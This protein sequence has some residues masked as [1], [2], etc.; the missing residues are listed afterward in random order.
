[1]NIKKI[2]PYSTES[3]QGTSGAVTK[4]N[5]EDRTAL[6]GGVSSDRLELSSDYQGIVQA[7]KTMMTGDD[8]RTEKVEFF[9]GQ[10]ESGEYTVNPEDVAASM[11][12]EAM[13]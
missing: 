4:V 6:T 9:R 10:V 13:L 12:E 2:A 3:V 11:M 5:S 8:V 1:M 7:K